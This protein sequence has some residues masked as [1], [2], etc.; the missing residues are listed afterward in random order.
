MP[1]HHT[2]AI[3][4]A[5]GRST[6]MGQNKL[7]L[8]LNGMP[9]LEYCIRQFQQAASIDSIVIVASPQLLPLV[10]SFSY[11]K[12]YAIT[13]GGCSR[14]A[15]VLCGLAAAPSE[16]SHIAIHDGARPF[17]SPDLIDSIVEQAH[18]SGAAA[19]VIPITSTVKQVDC[20]GNITG[21]IDRERLKLVQTPQVFDLHRYHEALDCAIRENQD[22]T[23]DCQLF[24]QMGWPVTAVTGS[25]KNIKLTTPT[26]MIFAQIIAK[27]GDLE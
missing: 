7:L 10:K 17:A 25:E 15:S 8:K 27:G 24:E 11:S 4:V 2:C 1:L 5:A 18:I 19:P 22:L 23:D 21:T 9:V 20:S 14:Q 6:R 16:T 26:D 13:E 3:L 12:I